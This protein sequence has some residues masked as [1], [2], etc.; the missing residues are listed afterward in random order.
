MNFITFNWMLLKG[1]V[2]VLT[3]ILLLCSLVTLVGTILH[4]IFGGWGDDDE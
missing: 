3:N 1:L 2:L 4:N